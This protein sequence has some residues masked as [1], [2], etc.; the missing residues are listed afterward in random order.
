MKNINFTFVLVVCSFLALSESGMA[1]NKNIITVFYGSATNNL[2]RTV[3]LDGGAG[4][5]GKGADLIGVNYQRNLIKNLA[6]ETGLEYSKNDIEIIPEF[7]PN[8]GLT[9]YRHMI[10]IISIPMYANYKFLKYF[11]INGGTILDFEIN[12]EKFDPTD[13]QSG[14]GL[15]V[16]FGMKYS[17]GNLQLFVNPFY[18]KHAIIPFER[19][20]YPQRIDN[21]G[22]KFGIG[23]SF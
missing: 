12:R 11:F 7:F 20:K 6:F 14:I 13:N 22:L 9:P 2:S 10:E 16:G 1:Q 15:G 21:T 5:K 23:Y 19:K 8:S 17:I 3:L 18:T 4:Y